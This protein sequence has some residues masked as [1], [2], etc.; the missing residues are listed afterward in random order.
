VEKRS[1]RI[2]AAGDGRRPARSSRSALV[3]RT[4][5][6]SDC[7]ALTISFVSA[8]L[9]F[10]PTRP[11]AVDEVPPTT[12]VPLF[13]ATLPAW[14]LVAK[15]FGLYDRDQ[16][17]T[18][19][20]TTDDLVSIVN[21]VTIGSW[22]FLAAAWILDVGKPSF[23]K[24]LT[25]WA[26]AIVLVALGRTAA[27]A[28]CRTRSA[29]L[30][31]AIIVGSGDIAKAVARKFVQHPEYGVRMVG[32]VD[33]AP[34]GPSP[35][36]V[37]LLGSPERLPEIVDERGI[38]RVVIAFPQDSS[39]STVEQ[40]RSLADSR[41]HVD[42]VPSLLKVVNPHVDVHTVE[43]V[44]LIGLPPFSLTRLQ[45]RLKRAMDVVISSVGLIALAPFFLLIAILIKIDS[46][47]PVFFRQLR[48]G[49]DEKPFHILKFRTMK[50]DADERKTEVAHL[51][52][53]LAPGGDPRMFKI[54]GDPRVTRV[55]RY[56]RRYSI[57]ELPQLFNVI[58]GEMTLVGP[59]PLILDED[60]HVSG[61]ARKRLDL[62]PGMTGLWQVL[63]RNE[64]PFNEMIQLDY[65]YVTSWSLWRDC[66]LLLRTVPLMLKGVRESY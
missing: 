17:R 62:K 27:R 54:A 7:L 28:F 46:R 30:Q 47:G 59:R 37:P 58:K 6:I 50:E 25:F 65:T 14:L 26:L 35:D 64:I 12:E 10:L 48:M 38:D 60:R 24:L 42:V 19:H 16:Q 31:S 41:V 32:F 61:W 63:G 8:E 53:H 49:A 9:L 34:V 29:Y 22:M 52:K 55:G 36:G 44:P 45:R 5:A 57:D 2:A 3:R 20:S 23:P 21:L 39:D 18:G 66:R 11:G 43:G 56:L 51:N 40:I 1:S 15:L 13:L 4:L 33:A